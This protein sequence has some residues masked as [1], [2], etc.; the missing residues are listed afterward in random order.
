MSTR[1]THSP[2]QL[3]A[4]WRAALADAALLALTAVHHLYGA[5]RFDTPWR[6]HVAHI[7]AWLCLLLGALLV[8]WWRA[9][10]WPVRMAAA[11]AFTMTSVIIGVAW[12]G[13]FEGAYNHGLKGLAGLASLPAP[14]FDRLFPPSLY[15]PPGDL[16]F[17]ISGVLQLPAGLLA[18]HCA[19][20]FARA[21]R[22]SS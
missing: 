9:P 12:L 13:L 10:V 15:E 4:A 19:R 1:P 3:A 22:E 16:A 6:G 20:A 5:W 17:E 14:V 18:G 8:A 21:A 7:A 2:A 11:A